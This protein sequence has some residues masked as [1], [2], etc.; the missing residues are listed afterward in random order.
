MVDF[1]VVINAATMGRVKGVHVLNE[2]Y[3]R[4]AE[5]PQDWTGQQNTR[6]QPSF[7]SQKSQHT[8]PNQDSSITSPVPGFVWNGHSQNTIAEVNSRPYDSMGATLVGS[9]SA[10]SQF[11]P[12]HATEMTKSPTSHSYTSSDTTNLTTLSDDVDL[13][14][15]P[16]PPMKKNFR[17]MFSSPTPHML[18][19][20]EDTQGQNLG[21]QRPNSVS[22]DGKSLYG[23]SS[24]A[25]LFSAT[26][27]DIGPHPQ[28]SN[29]SGT[30]ANKRGTNKIPFHESPPAEYRKR[31]NNKPKSK[32]TTS[33]DSHLSPRTGLIP[34]RSRKFSLLGG[35]KTPKEDFAGFCEGAYL[36][37][38][39][40]EGMKIRNQSVSMTGQNNYWACSNS[41]C[42]F[43]GHAVPKNDGHKKTSFGFDEDILESHGAKYRWSFLA[44]SHTAISNS[45]AGYEYQ[46]VFCIGR[47]VTPFRVKGNKKFIEHVAT[48]QGQ[49]PNQYKMPRFDYVVGRL[50]SPWEN[51]DVNLPA[52]T[53]MELETMETPAE[54]EALEPRLPEMEAPLEKPEI[55]AQPMRAIEGYAHLSNG[56]GLGIHIGTKPIS[57]AFGAYHRNTRADPHSA[58]SRR[59]PAEYE[60]PLPAIETINHQNNTAYHRQNGIHPTPTSP[61]D[62]KEEQPTVDEAFDQSWSHV[63]DSI[64]NLHPAPLFARKPLPSSAHHPIS[65]EQDQHKSTRGGRRHEAPSSHFDESD[66]FEISPHEPS[67]DKIGDQYAFRGG[68]IPVHDSF[69]KSHTLRPLVLENGQAN[70]VIQDKQSQ[71]IST[72]E[73]W[74]P[75]TK[76]M[77]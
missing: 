8:S 70:L 37:Q 42:C 69:R 44:K 53:A 17:D 32:S 51:F 77:D 33:Q 14:K 63:K 41:K 31:L 60:R 72:P 25:S 64:Q 36:L 3:M 19:T 13:A 61:T 20:Q 26:S 67:I 23:S 1:G 5:A 34:S 46:C 55:P 6:P 21:F 65:G 18:S 22:S 59:L 35:S 74:H 7:G 73:L 29:P 50:A 47:G 76:W 12:S 48:H 45:K 68:R 57:G 54:L 39:G 28:L 56:G 2:M 75:G 38:S 24:G 49:T 10:N 58:D 11:Y 66:D 71:E 9:A 43:E 27:P 52:A 30:S 62:E 4:M 40:H 16:A 15:F